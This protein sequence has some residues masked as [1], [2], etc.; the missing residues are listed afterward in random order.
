MLI[1][2]AEDDQ[3]LHQQKHEKHALHPTKKGNQ[4]QGIC[5]KSMRHL[6]GCSLT[7]SLL[8]YSIIWSSLCPAAAAVHPRQ[9]LHLWIFSERRVSVCLALARG[10]MS[11][12]FTVVIRSISAAVL[13]KTFWNRSQRDELQWAGRSVRKGAGASIR[14]SIQSHPKTPHAAA[15]RSTMK[16]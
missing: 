11:S 5:Q 4:H 10:E 7:D 15:S 16:P 6:L 14:V 1:P 2:V 12:P 3:D 9:H 8:S 13:T